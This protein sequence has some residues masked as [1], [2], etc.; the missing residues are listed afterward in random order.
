MYSNQKLRCGGAPVENKSDVA[1]RISLE[2]NCAKQAHYSLRFAT[3]GLSISPVD[4]V[5]GPD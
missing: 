5:V 1:L 3:S 2:S 4:P